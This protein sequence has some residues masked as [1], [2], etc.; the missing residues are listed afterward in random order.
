MNILCP[1]CQF[2]REVAV[3]AMPQLPCKVTCPQ[4]A[5]SFILEKPELSTDQTVAQDTEQETVVPPPV[6]PVMPSSITANAEMDAEPAGF[7]VR[8]VAA[9]VDS[10]LC[11]ILVFIMGF[12]VGLVL[13]MTQND[14]DQT[15]Q[16]AVMAMGIIATLFYYIFFTGYCGQTPGKMAL[17]IKV[18][19]R[20]GEDVGYGQVFVRE[21][22][23]KTIS[24]IIFCIGY[25][26]V[27]FRSDKRGLHDLLAAT[28]VIKL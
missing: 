10:V 15:A 18:V 26:M 11:N 3:T 14:M 21:T 6:P 22:I 8:V 13:G 24:S 2:S 23:G 7:W 16:L 1:H 17:R 12:G 4:C 5:E 27:G 19:H 20:N 9:L 28:K 25:L